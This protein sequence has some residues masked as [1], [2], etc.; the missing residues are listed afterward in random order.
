VPR[1]RLDRRWR[2]AIAGTLAASAAGLAAFLVAS[3]TPASAGTITGT[4]YRATNSAVVNWVNANPN[5]SR[6]PAIRDRIAS[7]PQGVW[8]TQYNQSNPGAIQGQVAA[9]VDAANAAGQIPQV[10]VYGIP[11]RDCGG[12]SAGGAPNL[13]S[14]Q[15]WIQY[16]SNG[17]GTRTAIILLETDSLALQTCLNGSEVTARD[18]A[19]ATAVK[20]IKA[21]NANAKVY[22]DGGHSA[23]NSASEQ[24]S[25]LNAAGVKSADGFFTNVANF[26]Y[27]ADEIAYGKAILSALGASNLHQIIDTSRNGVGPKGSEWCDPSGR[28]VGTAPTLNTGESTVDAY[29]WVKPPGE[30]DGCA[31]GAGTFLPALAY[32][33]AGG[34]SYTPSPTPS[35]SLYP[36]GDIPPSRSPSASPSVSPSRVNPTDDYPPPSPTA[37]ITKPPV[38]G[39]CAVSYKVDSQW[40]TGFTASVTI[41][42]RGAAAVNGWTLTYGFAGDQ[43]VAGLWNGVYTQSGTQVSVKN[44]GH[45]AVIPASGSQAFGFQATYSGANAPVTAFALNGTACSIV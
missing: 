42:N 39:G 17:L 24:A 14:Y 20:T 9:Y 18:N 6:T 22:L 29:I 7:Q 28:R 23:W 36:T 32:E 37:S 5:D 15:T 34:A 2:P 26:R 33:L 3:S 44:A 21:A 31:A 16:L 27:T 1:P 40:S 41:T 8:F 11:N 10:V 35:K 38:T 13:A 4:L 30:S 12:A 45:N 19:I 43:K 25:R